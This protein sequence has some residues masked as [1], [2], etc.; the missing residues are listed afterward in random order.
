MQKLIKQLPEQHWLLELQP[1]PDVR[2]QLPF[3]QIAPLPQT[4]HAAPPIPQKLFDVPGWQTPPLQQP[5]GQLLALQ[6]HAPPTHWVPEGHGPPVEPHTHIP[7]TQLSAWLGL[8]LTH[9]APPVPQAV[10]PVVVT[11][12]LP[13]QQPVGQLLALQTQAPMRHW[14]PEGHGPPVEPHT[15]FPFTQLS[16]PAPQ[17]TQ[18]APPVPQVL[19]V[20]GWQTPPLQQPVGQLVESHMHIPLTQCVPMGQSPLPPQVQPPLTHVSPL[21][22]TC[23]HAPQLLGSLLMLVSQPLVRLL[24][25]QS[26]KP[27]L[28]VPLQ[29]PL[30]Q[31]G[32]M[33]LDEQ[34][35]PHPPQLLASVFRLVSQPLAGLPLQLPK[36]ALQVMPQ[37]PIEQN[38]VPL[39]ELQTWPHAPQLVGSV[40]RLVSQPLAGLPSQSAK[41]ALQVPP[42]TPLVQVATP[43]EK[44][45]QTWP[46]V[47]QLLTSLCSLTHMPLQQCWPEGQSPE[48]PHVQE[49]LTHVSP[50]AQ[51]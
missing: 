14:V 11:H 24:L 41:P 23:P 35:L 9:A 43:L 15:H 44:A 37:T 6:T 46:H 34:T 16:A 47:P 28:Q 22:Q 29:T 51:T 3:W 32:V 48:V 2:Q 18:M 12:T 13:L 50:L 49:P 1:C 36:P 4:A 7:F 5:V 31:L 10:A 40:V 27:G 38:A 21:A 30:A 25:S 20:A 42:Q 39:V 45:G 8:Q 26:A 19:T 17:F 33:L